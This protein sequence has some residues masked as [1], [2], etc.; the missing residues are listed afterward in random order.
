MTASDGSLNLPAEAGDYIVIGRYENPANDDVLYV[1]VSASDFA[2]D[3]FNDA[4][5]ITMNKYLQV[6][7][8][9]DG[10]KVPAKYRRLTGSELLIIE[11]EY[12]L[13][14]DTEQLYPFIFESVGDWGV[15]TS[16]T[17][18]EGFVA[19]YPELSQYVDNALE[20]IQFTITE[21]GSDLVP[22]ET[23]FKVDHNGHRRTVRSHVGIFL[24]PAYA[25]SRGF[26]VAELRARGLIKERP[27]NRRGNEEHGR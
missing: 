3:E 13:W 18:P 7:E 11:P 6:I 12:V 20:A 5:V 27:Q 22:T 26:N 15:T 16:V 25:E 2:C 4:S 9:A 17:P 19:D 8:K 24:T 23:T 10:K 14:D 21:V 1:G